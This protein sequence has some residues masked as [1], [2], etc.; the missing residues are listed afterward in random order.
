M[1]QPH[2]R[3]LLLVDDHQATRDL[4]R[5][6]LARCGWRVLEAATVAEALARLDPPP[7]CLVLDL[8]LTDGPGEVLLRR[9]R[10]ERFPTRVV[11][12]TGM[13]DRARLREV[14]YLRPDAVLRKPLDSEGLRRICEMA[15]PPPHGGATAPPEPGRRAGDPSVAKQGIAAPMPSSC[16]ATTRLSLAGIGPAAASRGQI[17]RVM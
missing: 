3:L 5:R 6:A 17:G 8:D 1:N 14:S 16:P 2:R 7:D 15:P 10:V 12:T 9:V 4:L 13:D 11:V